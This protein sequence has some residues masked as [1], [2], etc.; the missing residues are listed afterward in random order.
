MPSHKSVHILIVK[1]A[2]IGDVVMALPLL[3]AIRKKYKHAHISW[4]CGSQVAP[5]IRATQ[6]VDEII[7]INEKVLL[8]GSFGSKLLHLLKI[9]QR[10]GLR[11]F[12]FVFNLHR[13]FRYHLLTM[14]SLCKHR[15]RWGK[16]GSHCC[17]RP[18]RYHAEESLYLLNEIEESSSQGCRSN[19]ERR[20]GSVVVEFPAVYAPLHRKVSFLVQRKPLIV[21]APGGAKNVLSD[22]SLRR[23]PV[24]SYAQLIQELINRDMAVVVIGAESDRWVLPFLPQKGFYNC[25]GQLDLID[26]VALLENSSLLITHDSGPMH[27]AKLAR[28]LT[29]GLFGPTNPLEKTTVNEKIHVIWGGENLSC[30]PCYN[31]K[32]YAP[33]R[34]NAC[35]SGISPDCVLQA[36]LRLL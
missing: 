31:G 25:I 4:L 21:I 1:I 26:L 22:D 35:L 23:W 16:V 33:C 8:A 29:I 15:R 9:W 32:T 30:R 19:E 10:L 36:A 3:L 18:G 12:D 6:L 5:L 14:F 34:N 7:E 20:Q 24:G 27:L 13:D 17:P 11:R 2:A 28:C